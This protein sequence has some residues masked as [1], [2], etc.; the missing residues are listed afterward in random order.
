MLFFFFAWGEGDFT[1]VPV[2]FNIVFMLAG[3][4]YVLGDLYWVY[5]VSGH[6]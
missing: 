2:I 6:Q 4:L 3:H 1:H 5:G